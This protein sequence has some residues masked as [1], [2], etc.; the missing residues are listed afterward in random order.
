MII[1]KMYILHYYS[2]LHVSDL[3]FGTIFSLKMVPK[4]VVEAE[5]QAMPTALLLT[6]DHQQPR[7][8]TP[9]AAITQVLIR[10]P[11]D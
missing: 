6:T 10:A 1:I 7:H 8:Y 4:E 2:Q 11:D 5:Q 3:P 9:Y